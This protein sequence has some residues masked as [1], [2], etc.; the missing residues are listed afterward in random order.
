MNTSHSLPICWFKRCGWVYRPVHLFGWIA[1]LVAAA[2]LVQVFVA[3]DRQAHSVTDL[4]YKF[5][6]Y[7]APTFLGLRWVASR[8]GDGKGGAA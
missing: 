8:T 6:V 2:F 5:Y 1:T 3:L 4:L 7:A